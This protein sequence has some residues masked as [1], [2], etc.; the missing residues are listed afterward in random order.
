MSELVKG[1][2]GSRQKKRQAWQQRLERFES[3]GLSVVAFCRQE[4]VSAHSF[5]YW[6]QRVA[7]TGCPVGAP[8]PRLLPVRVLTL[9][10]VEVVLPSGPVLRLLPG[11]DLD[12]VRSLV[13]SLQETPSC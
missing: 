1:A 13:S 10:P 6:K 12:F 2:S 11:C 3:S 8:E 5:Y 4:G 7:A 9:S